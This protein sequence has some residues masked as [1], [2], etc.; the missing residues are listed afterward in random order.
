MNTKNCKIKTITF[1]AI[2]ILLTFSFINTNFLVDN[3]ITVEGKSLEGEIYNAPSKE[4]RGPR[5]IKIK[6]L[7]INS[8]KVFT[9]NT[10]NQLADISDFDNIRITDQS[11]D[12]YNPSMILDRYDALVAYEFDDNSEGYSRIHLKSSNDFGK[13][14]NTEVK[15]EE[16]IWQY[17]DFSLEHINISSPTIAVNPEGEVFGSFI[18][19][20]NNSGNLYVISTSDIKDI[21]NLDL[22]VIDWAS[23]GFFNFSTP[24]IVSYPSSNYPW[25]I[26]AIGSTNYTDVETGEGACNNTPMFSFISPSDPLY[27]TI[28]WE[29]TFQNCSNLSLS[30]DY[31]NS[32]S[33]YGVCE[34]L[35]NTQKD[36]LFFKGDPISWDEDLPLFNNTLSY[37]GDLLNPDIFIK[38]NQLYIVAESDNE[39]VLFNSSDGGSS[40]HS[41]ILTLDHRP[42]SNFVYSHKGNDLKNISFSDCSFDLDGIIVNWSWDFGDGNVSFVKNP[43]YNYSNYADYE[44]S[45][46]VRDTNGLTS[47][48]SEVLSLQ[49]NIPI[50][51][52]KYTPKEA[53]TDVF[54]DF[55]DSSL[56]N[57]SDPIVNWTWDF[58][59]ETA[60]KYTENATHKFQ[61]AGEY[62]VTLSVKTADNFTSSTTR[63]ILIQ[64]TNTHR[65]MNPKIFVNDTQMFCIYNF[66]NNLYLTESFDS[67]TTWNVPVR[68]N[69]K[70]F[71]VKNGYKNIDIPDENHI[72]W[73]DIQNN[74][75]DIYSNVMTVPTANVVIVPGSIELEKGIK[76]FNT[77]NWLT[78][79]VENTGSGHLENILFNVTYK[80]NSSISEIF[81]RGEIIYLGPGEVKTYKIPLFLFNP[82]DMFNAVIGLA[83]ITDI[84]VNLDPNGEFEY[85][86]TETVSYSD[87]FPKLGRF[88][89]FFEN[90]KDI[91]F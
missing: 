62:T 59:D 14:W 45:L 49:Q 33:I 47:T 55:N 3:N 12:E 4:S 64:P 68:V 79:K 24:E 7:N 37:T 22:T 27:Q 71:T 67:A 56:E 48:Y 39:I 31:Y 66:A 86:E 65:R 89:P 11:E 35:N 73:T 77:H 90:I 20:V 72:V 40:W 32:E 23:S 42:F 82:T 6:P 63:K 53:S 61:R 2:T 76:L 91:I 30:I 9:E 16:I 18:S 44:V 58:G 78:F 36:L 21:E 34:I 57:L 51:D 75:L 19:D 13:T 52:F 1:I 43:V 15:L 80:C 54:V 81:Y 87:I 26:G 28:Y 5:S 50:A 25:V 8:K 83:G 69:E 85:S 60:L 74:N 88:E 29:P 84:T 46:A 17:E 41:D 10:L 38:D 70:Y